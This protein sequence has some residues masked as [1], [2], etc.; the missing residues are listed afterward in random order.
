MDKGK[1]VPTSKNY[2]KL[3]SY[4]KAEAI[5]DI[6]YYF[7]H[8]YLQ[9]GDR[10]IDQMQ[11]AARSG[12]QNIAE[13]SMDA[14]TSKEMEIKLINVAKGSL[15]ELYEDYMDYLRTRNHRIWENDS[16][17]QNKMREIAR[18]Y[19]DSAYYMNLIKTRPPE[20][21]ANI[22]ICLLKQ[23]D[24]LLAKHLEKLGDQFLK[25]G[26][27]KERMTSMRLNYRKKS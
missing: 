14:A 2:K 23:T 21:I 22:A 16:A 4:Q 27:F 8:T 3:Y 11:Q 12:K 18:K 1:L 20:T 26:G 24:Y 19:N 17:E 6:T 13:G 9:R 7:V 10:T 25:E 15:M 5:F